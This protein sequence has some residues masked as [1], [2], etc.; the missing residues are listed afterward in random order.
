MSKYYILRNKH[1]WQCTLWSAKYIVSGL[2]LVLRPANE[3]RRYFVR[4][5]LIGWE[6]AYNQPCCGE[7]KKLYME[8]KHTECFKLQ[9]KQN[10]EWRL[11][12]I[13]INLIFIPNSNPMQITDKV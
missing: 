11:W 5:Y 1:I 7:K 9:E 2:I 8:D 6:Q 10:G 4:S 12:R 13:M 3:R